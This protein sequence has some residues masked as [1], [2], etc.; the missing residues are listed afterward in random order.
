MIKM[1]LILL[2]VLLIVFPASAQNPVVPPGVYMAD[3]SAHV[4]EDGRLYIY[5]SV[6][7]S[8]R[9]YCSWRHHVL[10]T[11]D[12]RSWTL[13]EDCFAS[14]GSK[15]QVKDTDSLLFAP[16]CQ[17]REG[18]YFLYYCLPDRNYTEGVAISNNPLGPFTEGRRIELSGL[19][20]IDP[21]VFI[22]DDGQAYY[23]WGQFSTKMAK[24]KADMMTID[25]STVREDVLTEK[26]H[27][28]HEGAFLAKRK[29]IYYLVYAHMGRSHT[30]TCIGYATAGSPLG[31]YTYRG[32]IMDND[33]CDPGNW[34]NHG[35]I[36]EFKGKW[37]VFYH[38]STHGSRTM[39]KICV[40]PI[41]FNEDG[42]IDEVEM[43][44]QG[45]GPP[46]DAANKIDAERA[47]LLFGNVRVQRC[48][49]GNEELGGISNGD[50]VAYKYISFK[51][52]VKTVTLRVKPGSDS[53]RVDLVLDHPWNR[54][55]ASV[56]VEGAEEESDWQRITAP[57]Q[58]AQGAHALWLKF[59]GEGEDLFS[60]DWLIF[61]D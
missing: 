42:T 50:R 57:V 37:Y 17:H 56:E 40:E 48:A 1:C 43:T 34:N 61:S 35:S 41:R 27:F 25:P 30:P 24:L 18:T 6:D 51:E 54:A 12:M 49:E 7:E 9:Y 8:T 46:L 33:H 60:L 2:F 15:D 45:A 20:Q 26:E 52:G 59:H 16:D 58:E 14:K 32:V 55:I 21:A 22:D 29:G 47:C 31:P 3:P 39:R 11:P 4:W 13:H 5:G 38:R 28:F 23:V 36:A 53:G 44:T 10:S 19:N